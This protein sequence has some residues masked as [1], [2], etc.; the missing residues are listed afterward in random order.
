M[1]ESGFLSFAQIIFLSK[2]F[3]RV[4]SSLLSHNF[5]R[6]VSGGGG[7]PARWPATLG[8]GAAAGNPFFSYFFAVSLLYFFF[9]TSFS[10][11]SSN[12]QKKECIIFR[13]R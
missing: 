9:P 3:S 6:E 11:L 4:R 5:R 7:F 10:V 13:S 1:L 8:C 12:F 2:V